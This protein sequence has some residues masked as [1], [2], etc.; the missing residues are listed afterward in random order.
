MECAQFVERLRSFIA[1]HFES[2]PIL[3]G[4]FYPFDY[5]FLCAAFSRHAP[6]A[7]Y[8][9]NIFGNNFID[10]KSIVNER[11]LA[12]RLRGDPEPFPITSLSAPGGLK[13]TLGIGHEHESHTA[14]GDVLATRDVLIALLRHEKKAA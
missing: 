4:Q 7:F 6:E 8:G 5:A 1:E 3:V 2:K 13:D 11:N 10:T 12:A 9:D 14:L